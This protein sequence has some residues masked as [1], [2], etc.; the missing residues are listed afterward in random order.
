MKRVLVVLGAAALGILLSGLLCRS[1]AFGDLAG[2]VCGRGHL[3]AS[4]PGARFY[5]GDID[6]ADDLESLIVRENL[7]VRSAEE[8]LNSGDVAR[9]YARLRS[10]FLTEK[11]FREVMKG[12]G[13]SDAE[14]QRKIADELRGRGWL[15]EQ[16]S[17]RGAT[18][19]ECRDLYAAHRSQFALPVRFHAAH[20]FLAAPAEAAADVVEAKQ[21]AI[22]ALAGEL[23]H[24]AD[25]AK[26]AAEKS[27]DEATKPHGGDLGFFS[28]WRMPPEFI[29]EVAKLQ[30]GETS[31]PFRSHLGFHVVRL[32]EMKPAVELSFSEVRA[33]IA[34]GLRNDRVRGQIATIAGALRAGQYVRAELNR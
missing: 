5:E 15:A 12:S 33:E 2:R 27:E 19:E 8:G 18:D 31:K 16:L 1:V 21:A 22:A 3:L 28:A 23:S 14:L 4:T 6:E 13:L 29:D 9:E 24:G 30:P 26:L 10:Q 25:F 32:L 20:L 7:R 34:T 17:D 11:V